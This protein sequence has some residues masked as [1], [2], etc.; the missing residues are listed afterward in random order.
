MYCCTTNICYA[1]DRK[2]MNST[3]KKTV[4][5]IGLGGM[6]MGVAMSLLREGFYQ[7]RLAL[8]RRRNRPHVPARAVPAVMVPMKWLT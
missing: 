7:G 5:V 8:P 6:E 3:V 1:L 4:G 2:F